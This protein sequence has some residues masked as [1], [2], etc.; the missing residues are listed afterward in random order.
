MEKKKLDI[1]NV[2]TE[3]MEWGSSVL[4]VSHTIIEE[5]DMISFAKFYNDSNGQKQFPKSFAIP[6]DLNAKI[7]E[8]IQ[9]V[10]QK[11]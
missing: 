10:V 6:F 4:D 7:I 5:K 11:G 8:A 3:S 2:K 1:K 9:K